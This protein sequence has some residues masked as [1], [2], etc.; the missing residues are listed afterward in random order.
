MQSP[1][2]M[3]YAETCEVLCLESQSVTALEKVVYFEIC[4]NQQAVKSLPCSLREKNSSQLSLESNR[5]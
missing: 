1:D 4:G 2:R 5:Q 3:K